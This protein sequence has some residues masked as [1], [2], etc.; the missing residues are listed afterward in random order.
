MKISYYFDLILVPMMITGL[1]EYH[2]MSFGLTRHFFPLVLLG[3][4]AWS[5]I[6]YAVH[7]ALHVFKVKD[8][9][10]HHAHQSAQSGPSMVYTILIFIGIYAFLFLTMGK[11]AQPFYAGML[12]GY[13]VYLYAHTAV[14]YSKLFPTAFMRT[15]HE[16]H[17]KRAKYNYGVVTDIWDKIFR[18]YQ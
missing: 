11:A 1:I 12:I 14:H 17:H 13:V 16:K 10:K 18:T 5:F 2:L 6:E 9:A 3:A 15:H 4:V 7:R 8:H